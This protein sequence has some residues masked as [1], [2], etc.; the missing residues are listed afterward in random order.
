[1]VTKLVVVGIGP[2]SPEYMIPAAQKEIATADVV[3]GGRRALDTL[4]SEW[5]QK[6]PITGKLGDLQAELERLSEHLRVAVLVSGDPGYY[7]LLSWLKRTFPDV[8]LEVIPGLSSVQVAFARLAETWQDADWLSF[9]GRTPNDSE[10]AYEPGRKVAFLTDRK[11][12]GAFICRA[13]MSAGWPKEAHVAML[14]RIS[15]EDERTQEGTLEEG[16][17]WPDFTEAVV[18]VQG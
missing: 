12:S 5:Q 18:V 7:S 3:V 6:I 13:L 4:A 11:Q 1:M 17:E 10:L 16:A 2:G 14:E 15:Y 9:H 8:V